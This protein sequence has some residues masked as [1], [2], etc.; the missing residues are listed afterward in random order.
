MIT[1]SDTDYILTKEIMLGKATMNSDFVELAEFIDKTFGVK[2]INI[3]YDT[4]PDY[5]TQKACPRLNII[6]ESVKEQKSFDK[7]GTN[8]C[9]DSEKQNIIANQFKKIVEE[10]GKTD[11][12]LT[13]N[14]WVIYDAFKPVAKAEIAS[15][16]TEDMVKKLKLETN[17]KDLWIISKFDD[18]FTFFLYTDEQV[19]KYKNSEDKKKVDKYAF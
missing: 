15:N 12:Y 5:H 6:F 10:S 9:F 19:K 2:T 16:V 1:Y 8:L 4:M 7:R 13:E 18:Y 17:N 11:K 14:V 3:F